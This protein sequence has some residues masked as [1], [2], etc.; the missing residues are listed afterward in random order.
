M[1]QR[2]DPL[3]TFSTNCRDMSQ[4]VKYPSKECNCVHEAR[5]QG[6]GVPQECK[7]HPNMSSANQCA[8][9]MNEEA[10]SAAHEGST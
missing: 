1:V 5:M 10:P 2:G 4:C 3:S 7:A 8:T 9:A 6:R